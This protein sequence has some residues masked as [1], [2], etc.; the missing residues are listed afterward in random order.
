MPA[1][2]TQHH[3][4]VGKLPALPRQPELWT[5]PPPNIGTDT[6]AWLALHPSGVWCLASFNFF[7]LGNHD[8]HAEVDVDPCSVL[9]HRGPDAQKHFHQ[10]G[11]LALPSTEEPTQTEDFI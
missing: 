3:H 1:P 8:D 7:C 6:W 11:N 5:Q 4:R 10:C 2:C 9:M